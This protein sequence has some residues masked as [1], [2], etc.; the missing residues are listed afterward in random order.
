MLLLV[1]LQSMWWREERVL[2]T[3]ETPPQTIKPNNKAKPNKQ[4]Q[5]TIK[6]G[7]KNTKNYKQKEGAV[8][9]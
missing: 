6:K 2:T 1:L 8:E 3:T 9:K 4:T 5:R 7:N